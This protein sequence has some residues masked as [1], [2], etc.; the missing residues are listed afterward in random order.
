[1]QESQVPASQDA[2]QTAKHTLHQPGENQVQLLKINTHL[3]SG[4]IH[5]IVFPAVA[6]S[7]VMLTSCGYTRDCATQN[8][9]EI[10]ITGKYRKKKNVNIT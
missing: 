3:H 6:D 4:E 7:S 8:S 1:M 5:F 2:I 9:S 10:C